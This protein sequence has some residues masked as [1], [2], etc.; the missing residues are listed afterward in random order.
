ME[1][2]NI[3]DVTKPQELNIVEVPVHLKDIVLLTTELSNMTISQAKSLYGEHATNLAV[4]AELSGTMTLKSFKGV[5]PS[6]KVDK[7][8][9]VP[10]KI[11]PKVKSTGELK[12]R[13]VAGGHK[14]KESVYEKQSAP[15][16]NFPTTL[17]V[18]A[19][20]ALK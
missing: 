14:Q 12:A 16:V 2:E 1:G 9:I 13:L 15:T 3:G 19:S 10:S 4:C 6:V 7:E 8:N 5:L 11:F 20:I 18:G 17:I